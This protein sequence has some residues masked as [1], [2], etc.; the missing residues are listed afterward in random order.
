[1]E[2]KNGLIGIYI[3]NV[4]N[5]TTRLTDSK[6]KSPFKEHFN[7]PV[8]IFYPPWEHYDWVNDDGYNNI[9]KWVEKATKQAG[10]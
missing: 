7:T 1:M 6:G 3:H 10:R 8:N 4:K 5:F 9:G 2:K